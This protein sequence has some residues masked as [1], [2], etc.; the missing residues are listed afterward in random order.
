MNASWKVLSA[1]WCCMHLALLLH[2][3]FKLFPFEWW[4]NL[5]DVKLFISKTSLI[6]FFFQSQIKRHLNHFIIFNFQI[7]LVVGKGNIRARGYI[8][9]LFWID[10]KITLWFDMHCI[11]Q[12]NLLSCQQVLYNWARKSHIFRWIRSICLCK[13]F[14]SNSS[15]LDL[16]GCHWIEV[17]CLH[18]FFFS[19]VFCF[20]NSFF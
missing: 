20:L 16:H 10:T 8:W 14:V 18:F 19:L 2:T 7:N 15:C 4:L 11:N 1:I 5:L 17:I 3:R 12:H 6:V 13:C 9:F